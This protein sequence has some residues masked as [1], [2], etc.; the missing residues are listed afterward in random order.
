MSIKA[1]YS[2]PSGP[3]A[4]SFP[5]YGFKVPT[6]PDSFE[7]FEKRTHGMKMTFPKHA[8]PPILF[9]VCIA[10]FPCSVRA[11]TIPPITLRTLIMRVVEKTYF[12]IT[13]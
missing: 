1:L 12:A 6:Q 3:S 4:I 7:Y 8:A 2:C 13:R 9:K 5:V 11:L 10:P